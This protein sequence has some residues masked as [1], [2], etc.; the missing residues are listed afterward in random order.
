MGT[1]INNGII[2]C[3]FCGYENFRG[4]ESSYTKPNGD[5]LQECRW[6]CPRCTKVVRVDERIVSAKKDIPNEGK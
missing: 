3:T 6:I 5:I 2:S 1:F 4:K